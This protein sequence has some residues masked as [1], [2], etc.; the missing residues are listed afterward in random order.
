MVAKSN[1][2]FEIAQFFAPYIFGSL[3]YGENRICLWFPCLGKTRT[4]NNIL[5]SKSLIKR[6]L[7]NSAKRYEFVYY[8]ATVSVDLKASEILESIGLKMGMNQ[9]NNTSRLKINIQQKCKE[10]IEKGKEIVFVCDSMETLPKRELEKHLIDISNIVRI[11]ERR[12]HTILNLH[13]LEQVFPIIERQPSLFTLANKIEYVP[14]ITGKLLDK[15]IAS[16]LKNYGQDNTKIEIEKVKKY[17]GGILTL[18]RSF[19]R[20]LGQENMEFIFKFKTIWEYLPPIYKLVFEKTIL[21]TRI[22]N[23]N[24]KIIAKQ[25]GANGILDL[26][27]FKANYKFVIKKDNKSIANILGDKEFKILNY[28]NKNKNKLVT[29]ES[30]ANILYGKN[31]EDYSNWAIDQVMSRFRKTLLKCEIDPE[32]L[33]TIKGKGYIWKP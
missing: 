27:V 8:T 33:K 9:E 2:D 3:E 1:L 30:I 11:N 24:E 25:L 12:I 31:T 29:K 10:L 15:F 32:Q 28:L 26:E 18:T 21:K 7:G 20:N 6:I 5:N 13:F 4:I 19:I 17:T 14:T 23:Q 22:I 16:E